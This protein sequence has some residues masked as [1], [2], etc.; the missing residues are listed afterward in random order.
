MGREGRQVNVAGH[1][2]L[3]LPRMNACWGL[4][5]PSA[6]ITKSSSDTVSVR[7][8]LAARPALTLPLPFF[9]ST[10]HSPP[11]VTRN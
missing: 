8:A 1:A 11:G 9:R 3:S 2:T 7:S 4:S 5:L 6:S 10:T